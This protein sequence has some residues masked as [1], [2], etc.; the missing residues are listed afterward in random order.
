MHGWQV[1]DELNRAFNKA[2]AERLRH[3]GPPGDQGQCRRRRRRREP[4]RAVERLPRPLQED[5]G[6]RTRIPG[7]PA[8]ASSPVRRRFDSRWPAMRHDRPACLT[9]AGASGRVPASDMAP[10]ATPCRNQ[11][12]SQAGRRAPVGTLERGLSI[13]SFFKTSPEATI[14]GRRRRAR[15]QPLDH[16]PHRRAAAR[17]R[18]PRGQC[19]HQP[20]AARP[21]GGPAR[22][23]RAAIDRRHAGRARSCSA[24][25]LQMA[26]EAVNLA[27]FDADSMV[28]LYREQGPQS[29]TISS[30]LGSHRPMHA[31][32]LGKAFLAA[33]AECRAARPA[34][35]DR[36]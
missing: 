8:P 33:M 35:P 20:L 16:L 25:L 9:V 28:L 29:V 1:I 27:V 17:A 4:L 2:A 7:D 22:R 23:R 12:A 34:R 21:R 30:R 32:S 11:Q 10:S 6:R 18:L 14:P 15:P 26:G 36:R 5:L 24:L 31:S 13:L 19:Q 3:Q